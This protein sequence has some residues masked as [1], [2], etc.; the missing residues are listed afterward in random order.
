MIVAEIFI[1]II[2]RRSRVNFIF[3]ATYATEKH[4]V[5]ENPLSSEGV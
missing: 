4:L 3:M 2:R 5:S 1:G